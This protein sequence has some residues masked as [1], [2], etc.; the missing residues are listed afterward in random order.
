MILQDTVLVQPLRLVDLV[1]TPPPTSAPP[2]RTAL[3]YSERLFLKALVV[4][5]VRRL[6]KAGELLA[7]LAEPTPGMRLVRRL[8]SEERVPLPSRRTFERRA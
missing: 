4:M 2:S 1:P 5:I 6:H 7:V 3:V 8:L